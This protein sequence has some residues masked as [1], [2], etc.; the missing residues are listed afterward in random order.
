MTSKYI[1]SDIKKIKE[2]VLEYNKLS[3]QDK[4][5]KNIEMKEDINKC[6]KKIDNME[7]LLHNFIPTN[8]ENGKMDKIHKQIDSLINILHTMHQE[9]YQT[10]YTTMINNIKIPNT[11]D[12]FSNCIANK[13]LCYMKWCCDDKCEKYVKDKY[14]A[15]S[16]C[17][18][19]SL[20]NFQNNN[21]LCCIC[22]K[23]SDINVL[24]GKSY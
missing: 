1:E 14:K 8:I 3:I 21:T 4:M 23:P 20:D 16:L 15:K 7:T 18:P 17:I 22:Q 10:A 2:D 5:D 19:L 12:E 13:S 9:L 11:E 24:F 6:L